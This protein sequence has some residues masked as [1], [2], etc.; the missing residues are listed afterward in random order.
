MNKPFI[1]ITNNYLLDTSELP[2]IRNKYRNIKSKYL[3]YSIP[4]HKHITYSSKIPW[5]PFSNY[6]RTK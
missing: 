2:F 6:S 5:K 4:L 1:L 3:N